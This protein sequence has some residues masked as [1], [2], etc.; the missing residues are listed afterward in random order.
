MSRS[1]M[2]DKPKDRASVNDADEN[3]FGDGDLLP[4]KLGNWGVV[5]PKLYPVWVYCDSL[6][7]SIDV[8]VDAMIQSS[9]LLTIA[10]AS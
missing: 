10:Q 9:E 4:A 5:I 8:D 1:N 3:D 6:L 7:S 2:M